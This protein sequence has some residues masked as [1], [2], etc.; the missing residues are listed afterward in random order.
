MTETRN[1]EAALEVM[2]LKKTT[3]LDVPHRNLC[4]IV[5]S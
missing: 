5:L 3:P 1:A 4:P 2:A